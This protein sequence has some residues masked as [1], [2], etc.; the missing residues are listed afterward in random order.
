MCLSRSQSLFPADGPKPGGGGD[1]CTHHSP[2]LNGGG[3][4]PP[5]PPLSTPLLI[6]VSNI[7]GHYES[8]LLL[9]KQPETNGF[10][11]FPRDWAMR[12]QCLAQGR[13]CC[14][15]IRTG[16]PTIKSL[17]S[18]PL[19]HNSSSISIYRIVFILHFTL[20]CSIQ[21]EFFLFC[22]IG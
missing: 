14:Q 3:C 10:K 22:H 5:P 8:K 11:S 16:D 15:L 18:Y 13:N 1:D 21:M 20:F 2:T 7:P 17:W 12:T 9:S 4:I 6:V 19:S